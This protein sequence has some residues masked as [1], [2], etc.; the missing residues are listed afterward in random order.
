MFAS[1]LLVRP[2]F[3]E[4]AIAFFYEPGGKCN[5]NNY[6]N[7]YWQRLADSSLCELVELFGD[8]IIWPE[9]VPALGL[10]SRV[11]T[12]WRTFW[13]F[14]GQVLSHSQ[15]CVEALKKDLLQHGSIL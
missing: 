3:N 9:G 2:T 7:S 14:L 4:D 15:A 10:Q 13:L 8:K 6:L 1:L 12:P 5:M 11:F